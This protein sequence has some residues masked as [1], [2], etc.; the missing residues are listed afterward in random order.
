M[1]AHL[2]YAELIDWIR[3]AR[4]SGIGA[5]SFRQL[6]HRFGA[7]SEATARMPEWGGRWKN[8]EVPPPAVAEREHAAA[9]K[10]GLHYLPYTDPRYP[11]PLA[12][13][14]DAPPLLMVKGVVETL[15]QPMIGIVGA[16]NASLNGRKFAKALA[17]D[18]AKAGLTVISG[19]A[20][21]I[22]GGA[23]EG[24]LSAGSTV[25]VLAGGPD[26]I[27][28]AEHADLYRRIAE[29]GAV[30]SE[31]PPGTEPQ[32][33]LFPR[34]NRIISGASRG[35]V[36]VEAT[37]RSGSLI[38]A[39]YAAE[40]GREVFAVPGS[41]LDPRAH[42]PNGLI[43]EGATLIQSVED[44]LSV[45]NPI[46]VDRANFSSS[47]TETRQHTETHKEIN[48][49]ALRQKI[50]A[51]LGPTPAAVDELVRQCQ[52]SPADLAAVLLELELA[53][54]LE[55]LPGNRVALIGTV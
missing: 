27:Y 20:R 10:A 37:P 40:Q 44:F 53:G 50:E 8:A 32:A 5:K 29:T 30:I 1:A 34:R 18:L 14:D 4:S 39:R 46:I 33:A 6:L 24:A 15:A 23:H 13:L 35:I 25:A 19:M 16:R 42:G 31:M 47:A 22:D 38:T 51:A 49:P 48:T 11:Q 43:R 7:A 54:R 2:P 26:V 41:P 21:G 17:A 45:L 9:T 28:P 55:R 52:V 36:V 12:A 3:L